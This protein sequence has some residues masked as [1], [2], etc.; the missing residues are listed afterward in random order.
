MDAEMPRQHAI[1]HHASEKK[2]KKE[3][4]KPAT[5]HIKRNKETIGKTK[6]E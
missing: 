2:R 1:K 5:H 3:K 6:R 4:K